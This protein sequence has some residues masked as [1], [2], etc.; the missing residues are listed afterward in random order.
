MTERT[1]P[2][3]QFPARGRHSAPEPEYVPEP[4]FEPVS[5]VRHD[6]EPVPE[7]Q[8]DRIPEAHRPGTTRRR[9]LLGAAA[10]AAG[11]TGLYFADRADPL[12]R[13]EEK[14]AEPFESH[15][16]RKL[17]EPEKYE[18]N[19]SWLPEAVTRWSDL[20]IKH[21]RRYR[22]DPHLP[23]FSIAIES[24]GYTRAGSDDAGRGLMQIEEI[25][26]KDALARLLI[27]RP[28]HYDIWDPETNIEF[29]I[30]T[31]AGV[32]D[33]V[34]GLDYDNSLYHPVELLAAGYNG[35][36]QGQ[37]K[38]FASG[39]GMPADITLV[40]S[41]DMFNMYRE[42]DTSEGRTYKRWQERDQTNAGSNPS[43]TQ[44]AQAELAG[45]K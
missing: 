3:D 16:E 44:L 43:L 12:V 11:V 39:H 17:L 37:V 23:L 7:P 42:K 1:S 41:R 29:G 5:D 6:P 18:L 15:D 28:G 10:T 34:A 31:Y 45:S 25:A 24:A 35:G 38:P 2:T 13:L 26:E 20:V 33:A 27:N 36:F 4:A 21:S 30:A 40:Y 22:I 8:T 9:L 19:V 32:R 14:L